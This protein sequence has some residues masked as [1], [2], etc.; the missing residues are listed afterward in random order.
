MYETS[1]ILL[2][3]SSNRQWITEGILTKVAYNMISVKAA[4]QDL[5]PQDDSQPRQA[6]L[7]DVYSFII[8][9][10]PAIKAKQKTQQI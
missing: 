4:N 3:L 5:K 10:S 1:L 2:S 6:A 9:A 7:P 8:H